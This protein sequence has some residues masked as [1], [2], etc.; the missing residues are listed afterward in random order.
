MVVQVNNEASKNCVNSRGMSVF[1][2]EVPP[3]TKLVSL[4]DPILL[5]P[6]LLN[7]F[8]G[9]RTFAQVGNGCYATVDTSVD[10]GEIIS[11]VIPDERFKTQHLLMVK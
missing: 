8:T 6:S 10:M 1:A 3:R 7:I 4:M 5:P 9:R 2:V 11:V